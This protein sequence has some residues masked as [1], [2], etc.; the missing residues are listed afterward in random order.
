M[1]QLVSIF[2]LIVSIIECSSLLNDQYSDVIN[3]FDNSINDLIKEKEF[4]YYTKGHHGHIWSIAIP[5]KDYYIIV[6][7]NTRN[8][9]CGIDTI[10]KDCQV[11]KWGLD[12]M[13]LHSQKMD[14]IESSSD[15]PFYEQLVLFSSQNEIIFDCTNI[16]NYSGS[17]SVTFNKQLNKLKY[18][19]Y[20]LA[21]PIEIQKKLPA[22]L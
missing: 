12:S 1:K 3:N 6:S 8:D 7:G 4:L 21:T 18:L 15:W 14:P 11:L 13:A 2:F 17:D 22:P 5:E 16:N 19:M 10:F 20:W 9:N